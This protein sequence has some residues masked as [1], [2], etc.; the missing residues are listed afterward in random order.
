MKWSYNWLKQYLNTDLTPEQS[1]DKLNAIG[2]EV[3]DLTN[4][5]LPIAAKIVECE[6]HE[7]SDHLQ[8]CQINV[9]KG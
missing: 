4:P 3:E 1:A 8:S 2:L 6:P 7:N 9:G 5:I